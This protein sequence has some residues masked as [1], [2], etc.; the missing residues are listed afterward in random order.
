MQAL[1]N[2]EYKLGVSESSVPQSLHSAA[3]SSGAGLDDLLAIVHYLLDT[4]YT[5]H[6]LL[7]VYPPAARHLHKNDLHIR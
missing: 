6:N 3:H 7:L 1:D 2:V 5:L 4:C